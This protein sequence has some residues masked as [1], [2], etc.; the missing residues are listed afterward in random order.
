MQLWLF[1]RA[2]ILRYTCA[3]CLVFVAGTTKTGHQNSGF[4]SA[5][6]TFH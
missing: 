6:I 2:T 1:A 4:V 3:A 5:C